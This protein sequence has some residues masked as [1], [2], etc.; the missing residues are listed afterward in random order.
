MCVNSHRGCYGMMALAATIENITAQ[1]QV[2]FEPELYESCTKT[3]TMLMIP[4]YIV[5]R[6]VNNTQN[7]LQK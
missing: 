6:D 7:P 2:F 4:T 5:E 3:M 1:A